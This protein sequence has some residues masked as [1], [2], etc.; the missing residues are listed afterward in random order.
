MKHLIIGTAGHVDHGKT[1]LIRALT[2]AETD[3]LKEEQERGMSIDLGFASFRLPGG[4]LAGVIDVPGHERFLKNMLAGAGGIDL[5]VLVIAADEGVMPQT[6]EHL[7]ILQILQTKKGVVAITK[8]D[9]VDE[10]WLELVQEEIQ[11]ALRGTFLAGAPMIPV[12][13]VTGQGLPEL[14]ATLERLAEEVE[15]RPVVGPWRLPVDRAF[16]VGGFGTVV[17][18]TLM[19]GTVRVGD[20]AGILPAGL[21]TRVRGIQTHGQSAPEAEAGTRVALNLAGVGLEGVERGDVATAP[22]SLRPTVSLDARLDVLA[23]CPRE[24]KNRTRVRLYLGSA[25]LLARLALLDAETLMPGSSGLIQLRLEQPTAC[26]KG[27][28]FVLRFYSPMHTI[29]G[30]AVLEPHAPKHRRFDAAVLENLAVKEQGTPAELLEEAVQRSGLTPTT[31]AK[32]APQ[33]GMPV[34]EARRLVEELKE[35]GR[36]VAT[37]GDGMLH[38]HR[39]EAAENQLLAALREFHAAQPLRVGMSREELRSRLSRTMDAKSYSLILG[40]LERASQVQPLEGRVRIAGHQPQ[41][42]PDQARTAEAIEA[43]LL[44]NPVSP[45]GFEEIMQNRRLAPATAREVWEALID[46]G[47][48]VRVAEGVF[49]HRRALDQV[50]ERVRAHLAEKQKMTAAEF[51]DLIGSTRKYAVPLLEWLDQAR[52]TRRVGD[53]RILF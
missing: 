7:E 50:S 33:L 1:A 53:E 4:R 45:P 16:T 29:G 19:S 30:G 28:R 49:F 37:D 39:V 27:D 17:T 3:R 2:G 42:T 14:T 47:T 41:Y 6:R 5:V 11:S 48:V 31:P 26:A 15:T 32:V 12:S 24:V 21:E 10:E 38:A 34:E 43:A 36:L 20:R 23:S 13:S 52:V 51:R 18:G 40:R 46:A 8:A 35:E 25:E 44:E 22:G 9:L